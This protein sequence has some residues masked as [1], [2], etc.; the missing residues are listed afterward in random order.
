MFND[1]RDVVLCLTAAVISVTAALI[2]FLFFGLVCGL[3]VFFLLGGLTALFAFYSYQRNKEI[4]R[5]SDQL[6]AILHGDESIDLDRYSEG[7]LGIL[8]SEIYKMTVTLREQSQ[9]LKADK[10]FLADS[11]ADISHQMR[12]PLT[13]INII[14]SLLAEEDISEE[15]R[16]E[17]LRE[18]DRLLAGID[19]LVNTLLKI[20]G[21][22]A[23]AIKLKTETISLEKLVAVAVKPMTAAMELKGQSLEVTAEGDFSGDISWTAEALGN[24]LKN[25]SEHTPNG[26]KI[27]ISASEN[28]IYSE[29]IISDNGSG[30]SEEDLPNIFKRFYKGK[31]SGADSFGIG[32]ALSKMIVTGQNGTIRAENLPSGG[33]AFTLRFYKSVV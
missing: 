4:T 32:L 16:A 24:I 22:D 1:K 19:R 15:R 11:I 33:A 27:S 30:I 28:A 2:L 20:S 6:N 5:L 8:Q 14:T 7:A 3:A 17:L 31:N 13:S 18:L 26:G 21:F 23:G 12:T 29:I 9:R 25:C 10:V